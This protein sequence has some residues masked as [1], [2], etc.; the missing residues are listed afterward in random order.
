MLRKNWM[1]ILMVLGLCW[2][3][4]AVAR[5]SSEAAGAG[6]QRRLD[7]AGNAL[8]QD[9]YTD[10]VRF[11]PDQYP[12]AICNDGTPAG[13]DVQR[14]TEGSTDWV[15][16]LNGGGYC[17][18]DA[19]CTTRWRSLSQYMTSKN[20]LPFDFTTQGIVSS[21]GIFSQSNRVNLRYCS[22]DLWTGGH[23]GVFNP[24][25]P[26]PK[27]T[28]IPVGN[29]HFR[30]PA[31]IEAAIDDLFRFGLEDADTVLIVG[32]SAG[33]F[34]VLNNID[35]Y[36]AEISQR[37]PGVTVRGIADAG[38][39][40]PA[41]PYSGSPTLAHDLLT[42]AM[43]NWEGQE[44]INQACRNALGPDEAWRCY[45]GGATGPFIQSVLLVMEHQV[46]AFMLQQ[47]GGVGFRTTQVNYQG[48]SYKGYKPAS[49]SAGELQFMTDYADCLRDTL[50]LLGDNIAYYLPFDPGQIMVHVMTAGNFFSLPFHFPQGYIPPQQAILEWLAAVNAGDPSLYANYISNVPSD[51]P[52]PQIADC[53]NVALP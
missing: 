32:A 48:V 14:P 35:R 6:G 22:S 44:G 50:P 17:S 5:P 9:F 7:R 43:T 51:L 36:S 46:D 40:Y 39:L 13:Y 37:I 28:L 26:P 29:W 16:Y 11:S 30:G 21:A 38:W 15:I 53:A 4:L 49:L 47:F 12:E 33:G 19:S 27:R 2:L 42:E 18:D 20:W 1:F 10:F 45:L 41:I 3:T 52:F 23:V 8:P 24:Q 25:N 34:G 31:I